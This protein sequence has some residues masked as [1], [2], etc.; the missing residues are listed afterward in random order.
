MGVGQDH[1]AVGIQ[2]VQGVGG[3]GERSVHVRQREDGEVAE[4]VG[5]VLHQLCGELVD[6]PGRG[7]SPLEVIRCPERSGVG[8]AEGSGPVG[9]RAAAVGRDHV[10]MDV[11]TCVFV[12][13]GPR[14]L[15][16]VSEAAG[17][18]WTET[19]RAGPVHE[20]PQTPTSGGT[21]E[22]RPSRSTRPA[23]T[24]ASAPRR[25]RIRTRTH[26]RCPAHH[27][28]GPERH[29]LSR[30]R[31]P[32]PG[33]D[34]RGTVGRGRHPPPPRRTARPRPGDSAALDGH[35]PGPALN[36][37]TPLASPRHA[38]PRPD[39]TRPDPTATLS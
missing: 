38:A 19:R 14:L 34:G 32:D 16:P 7:P 28:R 20:T 24:P 13:S 17:A 3:F 25:T 2:L 9:D 23:H 37:H 36:T 18:R 11:D 21:R 4:P 33:R 35:L 39:P 5:P 30:R 26:P 6:V 22:R 8:E 27:L 31:R 1:H 10:L 29:P 15:P 12:H